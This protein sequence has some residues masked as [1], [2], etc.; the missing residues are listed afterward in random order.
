VLSSFGAA[1][2][3]KKG[4]SCAPLLKIKMQNQL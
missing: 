4:A 3:V 2:K 1:R